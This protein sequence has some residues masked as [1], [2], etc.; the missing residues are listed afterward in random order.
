MLFPNSSIS[1]SV[2]VALYFW[3]KS[4]FD[5]LFAILFNSDIG[6]ANFLETYNAAIAPIKITIKPII[7]NMLFEILT[8]SSIIEIGTSIYTLYSLSSFPESNM[9]FE[10]FIV[11]FL[12]ITLFL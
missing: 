4:N 7:I 9:L 10:P 12:M 3:L 8:L 6:V 11:T 5:I 1:S 2:P